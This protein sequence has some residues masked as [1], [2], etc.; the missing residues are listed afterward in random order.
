VWAVCDRQSQWQLCAPR[1]HLT[2]LHAICQADEHRRQS[3]AALSKMGTVT[4][5][6]AMFEASL[7][8]GK[9]G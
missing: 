5:R 4:N 7:K 6:R 8:P 2:F 3:V 9:H 1:G